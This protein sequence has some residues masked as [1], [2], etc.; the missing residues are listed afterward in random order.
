MTM[1]D[2]F[3]SLRTARKTASR[4]HRLTE[5]ARVI[6]PFS[7][8]RTHGTSGAVQACRRVPMTWGRARHAPRGTFAARAVSM[9]NDGSGGSSTRLGR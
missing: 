9:Q 2:R 5:N 6:H 7:R 8:Q 4:H 1:S 3:L